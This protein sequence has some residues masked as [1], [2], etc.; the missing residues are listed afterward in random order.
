MGLSQE[1][2]I[3]KDLRDSFITI[4]VFDGVHLGHRHLAKKL[5]ESAMKNGK[6]SGIIT[7]KN[8]PAAVINP[9][10]QPNFLTSFDKLL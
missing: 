8:H 6:S 3:K 1:L 5:I 4:G 9:R 2:N 7:F 10:F